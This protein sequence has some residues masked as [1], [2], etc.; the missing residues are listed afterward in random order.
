VSLLAGIVQ[1]RKDISITVV[2]V[3]GVSHLVYNG[4]LGIPTYADGVDSG[5][6]KEQPNFPIGGGGQ[7]CPIMTKS[8]IISTL[9]D[10][11]GVDWSISE[12]TILKTIETK[13]FVY[14]EP[15]FPVF[16]QD[17]GVITHDE[18]WWPN[19][20]PMGLLTTPESVKFP[21]LKVPDATWMTIA[22]MGF[23]QYPFN[24]P[25]LIDRVVVQANLF[26]PTLI[27]LM[28]L[29]GVTPVFTAT[30]PAGAT[31][32][33]SGRIT[34]VMAISFVITAGAGQAQVINIGLYKVHGV[35]TEATQKSPLQVEA[36]QQVVLDELDL[37]ASNAQSA[38]IGGPPTDITPTIDKDHNTSVTG[39]GAWVVAHVFKAPKLISR[40]CV[41]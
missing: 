7:G 32:Y 28:G 37:A 9:S 39:D 21:F 26:A 3:E 14:N 29:D 30:I 8:I 41:T 10:D 16:T 18:I 1:L 20:I 23:V 38:N 12:I 40:M 31:G 13:A 36:E 27:Q 22:N 24:S 17:E 19:I 11:D 6:F 25:K 5:N 15:S 35:M 2:D 33:D 34:P 4:L